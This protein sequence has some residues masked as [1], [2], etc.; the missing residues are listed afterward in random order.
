MAILFSEDR[1][2]FQA[3]PLVDH[4]DIRPGWNRF[5]YQQKNPSLTHRKAEAGFGPGLDP[6]A[7]VGKR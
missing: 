3:M 2:P 4:Q 5:R 6:A 1:I 7:S